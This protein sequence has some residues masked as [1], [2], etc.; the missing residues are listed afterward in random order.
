MPRPAYGFVI[1]LM[2]YAVTFTFALMYRTYCFVTYLIEYAF[3]FTHLR[4]S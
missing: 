4:H 3:T 2:E 1:Y